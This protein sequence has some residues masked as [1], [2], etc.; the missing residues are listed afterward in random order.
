MKL[1][2]F[3]IKHLLYIYQVMTRQLLSDTVIQNY[4]TIESS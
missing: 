2:Q 3:M 1:G 4:G